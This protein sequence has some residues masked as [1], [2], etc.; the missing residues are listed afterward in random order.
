MLDAAARATDAAVLDQSEGLRHWLP[1][2]P[3]HGTRVIAMVSRGESRTEQPLLWQICTSLEGLG[4]SVAVLDGTTAESEHNP[5]LQ[6]LLDHAHW[7]DHP[8]EDANWQ[9]VPSRLGLAR[10]ASRDMEDD[11]GLPPLGN[12]GNL[13]PLFK[14]FNIVLLYARADALMSLL[15]GTGVR[16]L[17]A[18][19]PSRNSIVG[20]YQ[21]LKQLL[22][23]AQRLPIL[24]SLVT[25][26][27]KAA[28]NRATV[29]AR[30]LRQCAATY[31]GCDTEV[32]SIRSFP[33]QD[34]PCE[35]TPRLVLR[36]LE[37]AA[38]V[39]GGWPSSFAPAGFGS[40]AVV[41]PVRSQ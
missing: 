37:S 30:S 36:L 13:G 16:P 22:Q 5:G 8:H 41:H 40:G 28:E 35:D 4:H 27:L 17:L 24:V 39:G 2:A 12:L 3:S 21:T 31:L 20:G 19:A 15:S 38:T 29:A 7:L 6:Q 26:P 10:L 14:D 1:Q 32:L 34:L 9:I 11:M 25:G 33:Q 18:I 23:R